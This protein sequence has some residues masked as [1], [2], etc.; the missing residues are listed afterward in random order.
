MP[1]LAL[2]TRAP[3]SVP[4]SSARRRC[5]A[6]GGVS[7][8]VVRLRPKVGLASRLEAA[9]AMPIPAFLSFTKKLKSQK[10]TRVQDGLISPSCHH[11]NHYLITF[12]WFA[13]KFPRLCRKRRKVSL[14]AQR[15]TQ[16][17]VH[18]QLMQTMNIFF[19]IPSVTSNN[20]LK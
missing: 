9:R 11:L 12:V 15:K 1:L 8:S 19:Q 17:T 10:A 14:L 13:S 3:R 6:P 20:Y 2:S 18:P 7:K 4:D 16:P 5:S